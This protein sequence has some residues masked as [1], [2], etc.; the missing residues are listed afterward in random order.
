MAGD[1]DDVVDPA[2]DPVIAV[3]VAPAAVA[4]EVLAGEGLEVGVDE[5]LMI[6]I[7]RAHHARP[8]IEDAEIAGRLA[9]Q[10]LALA[11]D[12][13][14]PDAEEGPRRRSRLQRRGRPQRGEP[15]AP[16]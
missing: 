3:L 1:V 8:S 16:G 10:Q 15:A 12:D 13:G 6:T 14:G 4:C 7:D 9:L 11:V 5:A 2:G